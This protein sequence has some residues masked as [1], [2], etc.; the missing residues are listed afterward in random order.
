M[1]QPAQGIE[2]AQPGLGG[3]SAELLDPATTFGQ[4]TWTDTVWLPRRRRWVLVATTTF[5]GSWTLTVSASSDGVRWSVPTVVEGSRNRSES[6]YVSAHAPLTRDERR[7][8]GPDG[9]V[10]L[11]VVSE[12]GAYG[13]WDDAAVERLVLSPTD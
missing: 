10:V 9:F 1:L 4:V 11:R 6:L 12:R 2:I 7:E 3:R 13:R 5:M 8:A